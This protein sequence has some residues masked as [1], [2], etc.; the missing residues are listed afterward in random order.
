M[1]MFFEI[2][3]VFCDEEF[4]GNVEI[5][6]LRLKAHSAL[7]SANYCFEYAVN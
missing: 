7:T 5:L 2:I 4:I 6:Q 1:E 3:T